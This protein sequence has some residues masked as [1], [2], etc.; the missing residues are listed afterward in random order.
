M[1]FQR[2][3]IRNQCLKFIF[4][5]SI[6]IFDCDSCRT[7]KSDNCI[8]RCFF[9]QLNWEYTVTSYS[10][11]LF[12]LCCDN[13]LFCF[14]GFKYNIRSIF[15]IKV[16][17]NSTSRVWLDLSCKLS[18]WSTDTFYFNCQLFFFVHRIC[19]FFKLDHS[20]ATVVDYVSRFYTDCSIC[21]CY[22]S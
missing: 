16:I 3:W 6:C 12:G 7:V 4:C 9:C 13:T 5:N 22:K 14:S 20:Y 1:F 11:I 17:L 2:R 15:C 8:L 10:G 18:I 21:L 19:I